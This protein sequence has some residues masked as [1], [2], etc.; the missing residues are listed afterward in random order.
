MRTYSA[1]N[2]KCPY[3]RATG[4]KYIECEGVACDTKNKIMFTTAR[5]R[6]EHQSRHCFKYPN[7]CPIAKANEEKYSVAK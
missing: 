7:E 4:D 5:R 6:S 1:M 2:V 3:Y